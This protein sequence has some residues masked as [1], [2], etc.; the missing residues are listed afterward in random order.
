[1][2]TPLL[3]FILNQ[4]IFRLIGNITEPTIFFQILG[5]VHLSVSGK[6]ES[7]F[8]KTILANRYIHENFNGKF[9]F[10]LKVSLLALSL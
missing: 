2:D 6:Y 5:Y 7:L 3:L 8:M 9:D 4:T 10:I 1:M